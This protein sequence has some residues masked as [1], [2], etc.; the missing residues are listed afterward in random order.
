[1]L[2]GEPADLIDERHPKIILPCAMNDKPLPVASGA[3][4]RVRAERLLGYKMA[5]YIRRIALISEFSIQFRAAARSV[6]EG[7]SPRGRVM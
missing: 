6:A 1:M 4:L 3:P 5:K 2:Y 7:P